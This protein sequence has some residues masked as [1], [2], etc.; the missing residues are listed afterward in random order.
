MTCHEFERA[1]NDLLDAVGGAALGPAQ[2][3]ATAREKTAVPRAERALQEHAASCRACR[4]AGERYQVL[5]RALSVWK[6]PPQA[7]ANLGERVLAAAG[8]ASAPTHLLRPPYRFRHAG[9]RWRIRLR[10]AGATAATAAALVL[11]LLRPTVEHRR[12]PAVSGNDSAAP[13]AGY[14]GP[15]ASAPVDARALHQAVAEAADATLE[16]ARSASEPAAR[17]GLHVLDS[18]ALPQL[19]PMAARGDTY[20]ASEPATLVV[21]SLTSLAPASATASAILQEVGDRF[22][23]GMQPLSTTARYAFGFLLGPPPAKRDVHANP[24]RA[25]GA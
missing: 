15:P 8:H 22:A 10:L 1:W 12:P 20:V 24:P 16:L 5:L 13:T 7:P 23:S 3:T 25:K 11:A 2:T 17:I 18:A 21:P 9:G 4:Q 19:E 14:P 6:S